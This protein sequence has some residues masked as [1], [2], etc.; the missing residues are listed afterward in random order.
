TPIPSAFS[1]FIGALVGYVLSKS[2]LSGQWNKY[3]VDVA[4]GLILGSAIIV[5]LSTAVLMVSR[6]IWVLPY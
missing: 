1:L 2:K 6:G 5:V 4:V 3:K